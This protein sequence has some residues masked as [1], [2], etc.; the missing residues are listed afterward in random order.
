M[1]LLLR[2]KEK[3]F[4]AMESVVRCL[5][6]RGNQSNYALYRA[7][8]LDHRY[9]HETFA[10]SPEQALFLTTMVV[11]HVVPLILVT[12]ALRAEHINSA[13]RNQGASDPLTQNKLKRSL[14]H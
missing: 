3:L 12:H 1:S 10:V 13:F 6:S 9:V 11:F 7:E 14:W 8:S 4:R 5:L 2:V